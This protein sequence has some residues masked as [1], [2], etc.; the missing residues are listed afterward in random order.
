MKE[1][2]NERRWR[3][4]DRGEKRWMTDAWGKQFPELCIEFKKSPLHESST[5]RSE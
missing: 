5:E 4:E 1:N 2:E 3:G